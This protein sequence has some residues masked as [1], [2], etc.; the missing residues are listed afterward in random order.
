VRKNENWF[1]MQF[2]PLFQL[3]TVFILSSHFMYSWGETGGLVPKVWK[4]YNWICWRFCPR[5]QGRANQKVKAIFQSL[6]N[7][8]PKLWIPISNLM[9]NYFKVYNLVW[10]YV[11]MK[12]WILHYSPILW[13]DSPQSQNGVLSDLKDLSLLLF[14]NRPIQLLL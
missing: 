14:L 3:C 9:Q 6:A 1:D 8:Q 5:K 13:P 12:H 11:E 7:L 2:C 10:D 4:L